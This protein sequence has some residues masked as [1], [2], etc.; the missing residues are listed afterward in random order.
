MTIVTLGKQLKELMDKQ[1]QGNTSVVDE[2][3][4]EDEEGGEE[5]D[6]ES[7]EKTKKGKSLFNSN[8]IWQ[9]GH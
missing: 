9:I 3:D 7:E 8:N 1:A 5:D 4:Y 2:E 6:E